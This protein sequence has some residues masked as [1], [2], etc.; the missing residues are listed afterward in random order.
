MYFVNNIQE[1]VQIESDRKKATVAM[2]IEYW[3]RP[4]NC[5]NLAIAESVRKAVGNNYNLSALYEVLKVKIERNSTFSM[6]LHISITMM[7]FVQV[8]L[9][10]FNFSSCIDMSE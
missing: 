2:D 3:C 8:L 5:N 9:I 7:I 6:S 1:N 4:K 10:F